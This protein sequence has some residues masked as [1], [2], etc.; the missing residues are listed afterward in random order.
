[1]TGSP[2]RTQLSAMSLFEGLSERQL[3]EVAGTVLERRVK[4]GKAVIKEGN[5]GHEFVLVLRGEV[6][7]IRDGSVVATLGAGSHVGELA[8]LEGVRRNATVVAR[9]ETI[10]G[11]IDTRLFHAL[12]DDIPVLAERIDAASGF[13]RP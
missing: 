13:R 1:M 5:W 11:A 10:V 8:V 9:S 6:D 12:L 7:V 2:L 4:P 3:N